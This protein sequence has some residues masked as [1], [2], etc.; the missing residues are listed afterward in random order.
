MPRKQIVKIKKKTFDFNGVILTKFFGV[1]VS[2]RICILLLF[3][4]M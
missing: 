4:Y 2:C 3:I 1:G